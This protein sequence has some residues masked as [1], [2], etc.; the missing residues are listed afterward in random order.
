MT[1][2]VIVRRT[3][4]PTAYNLFVKNNFASVK[5]EFPNMTP[6]DHLDFLYA[7]IGYLKK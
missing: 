5:Q 2:S 4:A 7:E 3:R 1:A 6:Q